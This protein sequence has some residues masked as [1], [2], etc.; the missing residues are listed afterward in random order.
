LCLDFINTVDGRRSDSPRRESGTINRLAETLGQQEVLRKRLTADV[1]HEL[2]TPLA[3]LQSHLEAMVDGI[4]QPNIDRLSSC[5]EETIR[6]AK[7][8]GDLEQ[9]ARY[10]GENPVLDK[11]PFDLANLLQRIATNFAGEFRNQNVTLTVQPS[12]QLVEADEDKVSQIFVNLVANA[13]KFTP[14][15]GAVA[16]TMTGTEQQVTVSVRDTGIGIA[17]E[18]LPYIFERFYRAD[19]SRHRLTGG[20]GI[21]LAIVKSLVEAHHG[22]ITVT[23]EPGRGSEFLVTLPR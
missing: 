7:L 16:I 12:P 18:D 5:H 13:L 17:G 4:W 2:R 1:A 21:G 3:T 22:S 8:V 19:K 9:L 15:G 14:S 20:S 6:L 11:Q 10:E 23:S